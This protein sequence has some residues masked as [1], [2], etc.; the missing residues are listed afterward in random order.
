MNSDF[1]ERIF[2]EALIRVTDIH[3]DSS[4]LSARAVLP[5][6]PINPHED[7]EMIPLRRPRLHALGH[8]FTPYQ[9]LKRRQFTVPCDMRYSE[10]HV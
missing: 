1:T 10:K 2:E 5:K 6:S 8:F 4:R 7:R 9:P 3:Q